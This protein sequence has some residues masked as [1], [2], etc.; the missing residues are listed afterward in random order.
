MPYRGGYMRHLKK[1]QPVIILLSV[2]ALTFI[3]YNYLVKEVQNVIYLHIAYGIFCFG[4]AFEIVMITFLQF[5]KKAMFYEQKIK[6]WNNISYKVMG[7]EY[8]TYYSAGEVSLNVR[9]W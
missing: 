7:Y 3:A 9:V 1:L 8:D 6:L 5:E 2:V 4:L